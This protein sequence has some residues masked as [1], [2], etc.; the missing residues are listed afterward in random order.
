[1]P[2]DPAYKTGLALHETNQNKFSKKPLYQ[3]KIYP[4][5]QLQKS[6]LLRLLRRYVPRNGCKDAIC[7]CEQRGNS[8]LEYFCNYLF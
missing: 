1:M 2:L 5:I 3:S 6:N 7:H 8:L 4:L